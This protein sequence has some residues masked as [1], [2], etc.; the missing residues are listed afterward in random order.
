MAHVSTSISALSFSLR[1]A[2]RYDLAN[3]LDC[4]VDA[5][6]TERNGADPWLVE[7]SLRLLIALS[8]TDSLD[9]E[10]HELIGCR[11][12]RMLQDLYG[13]ANHARPPDERN[14]GHDQ[15]AGQVSGHR[16]TCSGSSLI[17]ASF[18]S[19]KR[20]ND[21]HCLKAGPVLSATLT[22]DRGESSRGSPSPG[23]LGGRFVLPNDCV[24]RGDSAIAST[25]GKGTGVGIERMPWFTGADFSTERGIPNLD[26][27]SSL[28]KCL[29]MV[30][31]SPLSPTAWT[32][33]EVTTAGGHRVPRFATG[34]SGGL[35]AASARNNDVPVSWG[36]GT[37]PSARGAVKDD[38]VDLCGALHP[39]RAGLDPRCS[40][41]RELRLLLSFP[42][43]DA[44][45]K[46]LLGALRLDTPNLRRARSCA[47]GPMGTPAPCDTPVP[48]PQQDAPRGPQHQ[49]N[50]PADRT[51]GGHC[52]FPSPPDGQPDSPDSKG[53]AAAPRLL[54]VGWES[55]ESTWQ[56]PASSHG[57]ALACGPLV[58][59]EGV[60]GS[61]A[62]ETCYRE[63][64][65]GASGAAPPPAASEEEMVRRS[66]AAMHGVPSDTFGYDGAAACM[67][68]LCE[69]RDE[70]P[71]PDGPVARDDSS[72]G[73]T[74]SFARPRVPGLSPHALCSL[75]GE[76][77]EAGT[78]YRRVE[79]FAGRLAVASSKNG[80]V[81]QAFAAE[82]RRQLADLAALLLAVA[83]GASGASFPVGDDEGGDVRTGPGPGAGRRQSCS[84]TEALHRTRI[85]RKRAGALAGICGLTSRDLGP[86]GGVR[87]VAEQFPRGAALLSYLYECLNVASESAAQGIESG[88]G[89]LQAL[90]S[91][92]SAPYLAMLSRWLWLGEI[93][94][95]DDPFEEFPL[96]CKNR[97]G[98]AGSEGG[99][100]PGA[101]MP[102][103]RE[104]G[105]DF[106]TEA[107]CERADAGTPCFID[108]GV[109]T[110]ATTAG[111]LLRML[112]VVSRRRQRQ[113]S[114]APQPSTALGCVSCSPVR[115]LQIRGDGCRGRLCLQHNPESAVG[116]GFLR[117]LPRHSPSASPV[118]G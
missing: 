43:L 76:F 102:W 29:S 64:F 69:S 85:A 45:P 47:R 104:G 105:S 107:F 68:L 35:P 109:F 112:K 32:R 10:D 79:E 61:A 84:L 8:N 56:G 48:R 22:I 58:T 12:W 73:G 31:S 19:G 26:G 114:C 44:D 41:L 13:N 67:R 60:D 96:R 111:K 33:T 81:V 116:P 4:L 99:G 53:N 92:A 1:I 3:A 57:W 24:L 6:L 37:H 50:R 17:P 34:V 100:R 46:D 38:R 40:E 83:G 28:S 108:D 75:L 25:S 7:R 77:A 63:H 72:C 21:R 88:E 16:Q 42:E 117:A 115:A 78:W 98:S 82:L 93:W 94:E 70:G 91:K 52:D 86:A 101:E 71:E 51:L 66:V 113:P 5:S 87:G 106:M 15:S 11:G 62:F 30:V 9:A 39:S 65:G 49:A 2:R 18:F 118:F 110:A 20:H 36:D 80:L 59:G 97:M 90:L 23:T 27:T 103:M 55:G 89:F 95:E 14:G 74:Q 54:V